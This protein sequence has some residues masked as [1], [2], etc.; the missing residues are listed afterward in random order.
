MRIKKLINTRY[1]ILGG[2]VLIFILACFLVPRVH[3]NYKKNVKE[4][5]V[6]YVRQNSSFSA[7]IDSISP[8]LKDINS[9]IKVANSNNL[10]LLFKPGRYVLTSQMRNKDIVRTIISG[11][12]SPMMLT[13]G[14]NIRNKERLAAILGNKLEAD[15]VAFIACFNDSLTWKKCG[16][17]AETFISLFIPNSYEVYWTITPKEFIE[18]MKRERESFWTDDRDAK[19]KALN[20]SR[21]EVST[22][23]SIVCEESNYKPELPTIAGVYINRL[24]KRIKL[25]ADP[26]VKFACGDPSIRRI[27]FKHLAVKS[28]YNTY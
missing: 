17:K 23:A 25:D 15:S 5:A 6:L 4:K 11:W 21:E 16:L 8:F 14:G 1:L 13:L 24:K 28:P 20:L 27:L 22:L 10:Q 12:Q 19:A 9:F 7:V 18:R 3:N 26:T 2:G